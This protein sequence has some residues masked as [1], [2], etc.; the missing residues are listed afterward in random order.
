MTYHILDGGRPDTHQGSGPLLC[1]PNVQLPAGYPFW[2]H[3]TWMRG[4]HSFLASSIPTHLEL[5]R[6]EG[7]CIPKP[8]P[9]PHPE[10][11]LRK[12]WVGIQIE[13]M[14]EYH[15]EAKSGLE[16]VLNRVEFGSEL[17]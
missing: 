6:R 1:L 17:G 4:R 5:Y 7:L 12:P 15:Q 14:P 3:W 16:T 11:H 10:L 2:S 13:K 8:L 9:Q